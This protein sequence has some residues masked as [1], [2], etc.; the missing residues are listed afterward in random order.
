MPNIHD[1]AMGMGGKTLEQ[2]PFDE[3]DSLIVTQV[4]YLPMEGFLDKGEERTLAELAEHLQ[5]AYPD[6]FSDPFQKK[7]FAMTQVCAQQPR[8]RD[9]RL[10]HYVSRIDPER[11]MQFAACSFDLP[12]GQTVVAF[13]GTDWSLVG[14][15]EDLNMSFMTVPSQQEAKEYVERV[16]ENN[17][18]GLILCG[19]SK[20]GNLAVYAGAMVSG[21]TRDRLQRIHSFDGPGLDEETLSSLGY[22]LAQDRIESFI[23]QSSVVGMLLHYHPIYTVVHSNTLGILQHDAMTWQVHEGSFVTL[24]GVDR[25]GRMTDETLH[26][27]LKEMDMDARRLLVDTLYQVLEAAQVDTITGL[28]ADWQASAERMLEAL[29]ELN[30]EVRRSVRHMLSRLFSTGAVEA[31]RNLLPHALLTWGKRKEAPSAQDE[32]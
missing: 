31:L 3:I 17:G 19:H 7:R 10:H 23:P 1:H 29:R 25:S 15:K 18:R 21:S 4:V 28:V 27:W 2:R 24:E 5:A 11:E 13:R 20:G 26:A 8:Y 9:W 22:Q 32:A 6:G 12:T 30:P 16:A 14:W